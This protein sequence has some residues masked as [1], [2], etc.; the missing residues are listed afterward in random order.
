MPGRWPCW[1][2]WSMTMMTTLLFERKENLAVI[3]V[4]GC[5][6]SVLLLYYPSLF[7]KSGCVHGIQDLSLALPGMAA[8]W[9]RRRGK[10]CPYHRPRA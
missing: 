2:L 8:A 7:A 9:S 4:G 10:H 1:S 3:L 5:Q 6:S